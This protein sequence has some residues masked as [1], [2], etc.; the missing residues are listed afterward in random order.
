[1]KITIEVPEMKCAKCDATAPIQPH[2][3]SFKG[4]VPPQ[5]REALSAVMKERS[6]VT[7]ADD[8]GG[9]WSVMADNKPAGWTKG[10][11]SVDLCTS[12]T[13]LWAEAGK[14]FL[15]PPPAPV[16]L[17]EEP[18]VE[19]EPVDALPVHQP[20][21]EP[22]MSEIIAAKNYGGTTPTNNSMMPMAPPSPTRR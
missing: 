10:P 21:R 22:T 9:S 8:N 16:E 15:T 17:P 5:L 18:E 7:A 12:C 6:D 2:L 1:M 3:L 11:S 20:R 19:A 4:T 13:A 14:A